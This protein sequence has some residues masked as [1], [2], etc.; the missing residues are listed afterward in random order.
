[1]YQKIDFGPDPAEG[2]HSA[3]Q[4][5]LLDFNGPNSEEKERK[6]RDKEEG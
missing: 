2:A 3:P 4:A 5:L 1:M 6:G